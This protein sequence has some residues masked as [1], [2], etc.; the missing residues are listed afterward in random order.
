MVNRS[1]IP[2]FQLRHCNLRNMA[3][4]QTGSS[5]KKGKNLKRLAGKFPPGSA[6]PV[7]RQ[8]RKVLCSKCKETHSAPTGRACQKLESAHRPD[9]SAPNP[10]L[11]STLANAQEQHPVTSPTLSP[12]RRDPA[13]QVALDML[14]QHAH[15]IANASPTLSPVRTEPNVPADQAQL[16]N[17]LLDRFGH[18]N[19]SA[20]IPPPQVQDPAPYIPHPNHRPGP[21]TQS[22]PTPPTES[23]H[24]KNI[25]KQI[26]KNQ[27][28]MTAR[29]NELEDRERER[30]AAP[31]PLNHNFIPEHNRNVFSSQQD[32]WEA[33]S[34]TSMRVGQHIRRPAADEPHRSAAHLPA[35]ARDSNQ[36]VNQRIADLGDEAAARRSG[37]QGVY[38]SHFNNDNYNQV[39]HGN[40]QCAPQPNFND[41]NPQG[42]Y[43]QGESHPLPM[44][45][46]GSG[47][48][49]T[50]GENTARFAIPW[51]NEHCL[52]GVDRRQVTYDQL[53]HPQW[54][55][56]LM[57][58]LAM[59]RDPLF[60]RNM[61]RHITRLS[62]DVAD[63]GFRVTRGAHA[64]VLVALEEGRVSWAEP[65]AIE[66]IRRDAVSRVYFEAEVPARA[67][68]APAASS[69][70]KARP[71]GTQKT[72]SVCK[73]YNN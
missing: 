65:E 18:N 59:E 66:M 51:P 33:L 67:P 49:R 69:A 6:S 37:G 50:G 14:Q 42:N 71:Q 8:K 25:L 62:Q 35:T 23:Q 54:Q 13:T 48:D 34:N 55:A 11:S 5:S 28:D 63:C 38:P 9:L 39:R 20:P 16:I 7:V 10:D 17:D 36:R 31:Q 4:Q 53:T 73:H 15:L 3:P 19:R 58:I 22:V 57:N 72:H 43:P 21:S 52:I 64:A 41:Y 32:E 46:I 47:R 26:L 1:P 2:N 24:I 56:G 45:R 44:K 70:A 60:H 40:S 30:Y 61:L 68:S 29:Q 12:V 27:D